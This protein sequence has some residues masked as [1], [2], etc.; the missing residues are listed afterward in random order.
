MRSHR[1][2]KRT[3][4]AVIAA[5]IAAGSVPQTVGA[6]NIINEKVSA[7]ACI[8][9]EAQTGAVLFSENA[10]ERLPMASTT[11]IMT[12]L[13]LLESGDP[14]TPFRVDKDAVHVEGSSMGLTEN[15]IVT[16]RALC[17]GMLLPSGN[18]AANVTAVHLAGNAEDFA[19]LMNLRAA[20]IG[21]RDTHFVTPS[22]LHDDEHYSTAR[23]MSLLAA[24]ALKEPG[25]REICS[26]TVIKTSFGDPPYDRWLRNTNRLLT[27][28]EGCIGVKTGFTDEAGRCLV[29]AC[30]RNGITLI[31]VTLNDRDDW[32]D[33]IR[34]YESG[35]RAVDPVRVGVNGYSEAAAGGISDTVALVP[36]NEVY[37]PCVGG[38]MPEITQ[39]VIVPPFVYAPVHSGDAVGRV[40]FSADGKKFA[41]CALIAAE[42]IPSAHAYDAPRTGIIGRVIAFLKGLFTA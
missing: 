24:E 7:K 1:S 30:E 17:A 16:A 10:D 8:L 9:I 2:A 5:F 40:E 28:C 32:N 22:G 12:A 34:L 37:F 35:F 4:A 39:K 36:E 20:A 25:F 18:D 31:C 3:S 27:M 33:H 6:E 23:D 26:S 13:L 29:S 19:R 41:E 42:D 21:M 14:D 38:D 11:K 15:D